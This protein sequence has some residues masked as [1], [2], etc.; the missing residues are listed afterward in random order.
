[1]EALRPGVTAGKAIGSGRLHDFMPFPAGIYGVLA[2]AVARRSK[3]LAVR[4]AI[5][6]TGR[7]LVRFVT[8]HSLRLVALG[9]AG[10]VGATF[11]LARMVRAGGGGGSMFDANWPAFLIPALIIVVVGGL[12]TWIPSRRALKINPSTLLRTS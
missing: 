1:M 11:V 7:D 12:A 9:A 8:G 5:G 2:F 6:A 4:V 10:G 3:E